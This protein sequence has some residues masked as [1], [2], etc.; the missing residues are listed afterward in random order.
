[1]NCSKSVI[2]DKINFDL[3]YV[4]KMTINFKL[5]KVSKTTSS[6]IYISPDMEKLETSNLDSRYTSFKGLN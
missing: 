4:N 6:K 2:I 5:L 3:P 1:M